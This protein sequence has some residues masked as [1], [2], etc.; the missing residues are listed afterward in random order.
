MLRCALLVVSLTAAAPVMGQTLWRTLDAGDEAG[1]VKTKL[2]G[3]AEVKQVKNILRNKVFRRQDINMQEGGVPIFDGHFSIQTD[4]AANALSTV[5]L[6]SGSGCARD[7]Y[8]LSRKI[9]DELQQK[10]PVII[11]PLADEP[12]FNLKMLDADSSRTSSTSAA[13]SNDATAVIMR[14]GFVQMPPPSYYGGSALSRS[15]YQI[16]KSLYD[17][18][19]ANCGGAWYRSAQI[20]ITYLM[21]ADL[22]ARMAD[23]LRSEEAAAKQAS[24][25]L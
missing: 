4:F 25:N 2:E 14:V 19:A 10:Y 9:A 13:W 20:T 17:G 12:E 21:R 7:A 8:S 1:S 18:Q 23:N 6:A 5:T 24:G 15:L 11:M 22:E 16:A 3:M